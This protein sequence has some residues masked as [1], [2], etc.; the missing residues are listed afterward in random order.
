MTL[1]TKEVERLHNSSIE[2]ENEKS[3]KLRLKIEDIENKI[4]QSKSSLYGWLNDN[5]DDWQNTIGKVI[6]EDN[7]LFNSEL[8]P[9]L[10]ERNSTTLFGVELNLNTLQ[11][12]VKS[13]KEYHCEIEEYTGRIVEIKK[14]CTTA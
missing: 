1:E 9:K 4:Q 13:V 10:V 14:Y 12:R 2:K 11:N 6:D 7:V 8:N 3:K 5:I